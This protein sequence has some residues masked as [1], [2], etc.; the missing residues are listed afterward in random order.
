MLQS[1]E[2]YREDLT[3]HLLEV[4]T[5]NGLLKGTLLSTPDIDTAWVRLAPSFYGDAVREF[6]RYPEFCL[7][8]AGYLGMAIAFLWDADWARYVE[9]PYAF[10]QGKRGFDDMDDHITDDILRDRRHSV[11]AMQSTAASAYHFLMRESPEPGTAEAYR[12]FLA[13]MEVM[14]KVGAAIELCRQG[15]K[16][17]KVNLT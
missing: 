9:V 15:Y 7:G 11:P 8:C 13:T 16:F 12:M 4:C 14:F 10:F 17:E 3:A 6:N 5:G 1:I 2:K